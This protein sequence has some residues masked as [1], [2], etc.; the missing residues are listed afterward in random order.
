M[1]KCMTRKLIIRVFLS[2]MPPLFPV[3]SL[4]Q[5]PSAFWPA[6]AD[7]NSD[8]R[9]LGITPLNRCPIFFLT[10]KFLSCRGLVSCW[11]G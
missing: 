11:Q 7:Y 2:A 9:A 3:I 5:S 10:Q 4:A 6:D 8:I 1:R